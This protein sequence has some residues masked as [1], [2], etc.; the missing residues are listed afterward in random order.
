MAIGML[1]AAGGLWFGYAAWRAHRQ[2]VTLDVRELPLAD[3][4]RKIEHQT[5]TKIRAE[6]GLDAR[7]TLRVNDATLPSVLDRIAQQAGARW[8]T[9]YAVY[10]SAH[11]LKAL[12]SALR[13]DGKLEPV[14]WTR[15][16]PQFPNPDELPEKGGPLSD[17]TTDSPRFMDGKAKPLSMQGGNLPRPDASE[18]ADGQRRMMF[19]AKPNGP[20]IF[21]SGPDGPIELWSPEELVAE[22]S[23]S[24]RISASGATRDLVAT[25]DSAARTARAIHGKWTTYLTFRKSNFGIG[26]GGPSPGPQ[27]VVSGRPVPLGVPRLN[28]NV[29]FANLTPEQRVQQARR[30]LPER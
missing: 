22:T 15:V 5:W 13:R 4:L 6:N 7:I 29:G 25:T 8:S 30:H 14:G 28:P 24:A 19:R 11:A 27:H 9:V 26:F 10:D 23:L 17:S 20:V 18:S 2:L 16:A 12:D 3:I 1:L 21:R